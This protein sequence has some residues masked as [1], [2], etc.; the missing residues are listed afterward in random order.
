MVNKQPNTNF[1]CFI[2]H[3]K[4][5]SS[6]FNIELLKDTSLTISEFNEENPTFFEYHL[7]IYD[8]RNVLNKFERMYQG[9][10]VFFDEEDIPIAKQITKSLKITRCPNSIL[11]KVQSIEFFDDERVDLTTGIVMDKQ[12]FN[13]FLK[14]ESLRT[15]IIKTNKNEYKCNFFGVFSSKIIHEILT[16]DHSINEYVYDFDDEFDEFQSVCDIFNFQ[17]VDITANNMNSLKEI[18]EDLSIEII[19]NKIDKFI[20]KYEKI[21]DKIDKQQDVIDSIDQLFD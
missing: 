13:D 18:A 14:N 1:Y 16:K 19:L 21:S 20:D 5:G 3:T 4:N 12:S 9:K 11:Q 17:K 6:N 8:N 10:T 7:N 2:I 15:F